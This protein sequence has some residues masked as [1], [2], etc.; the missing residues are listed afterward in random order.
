MPI[1]PT[2]IQ[3]FLSG[4]SSNTDPNLSLGGAISTTRFLNKAQ[5]NL[6]ADVQG[7]EAAAGST[8]YRCLYLKN[9]HGTLTM[10][11]TKFYVSV[12]TLSTDDTINIGLGTSG[13]NGTEQSIAD[14]NTAPVGVSFSAP[15]SNATGILIGNIPIGQT[16]A[17][18]FQRVVNGPV[19]NVYFGNTFLFE[20]DCNTGA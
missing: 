5:D 18:W 17:L 6:F 20:I 4:G 1:L 16:Y 8:K 12:N 7:P 9:G 2:D 15:T 11:N 19:A 14:E 3:Y 10:Q 13:L